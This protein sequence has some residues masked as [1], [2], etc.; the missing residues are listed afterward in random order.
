MRA[1]VPL[2][3][4]DVEYI[5]AG[6]VTLEALCTL[7]A[8][9]PEDI[10]ALI[11]DG[12]LPCPSYVL[13]DGTE[14]FPPD[15]FSLVDAAGGVDALPAHFEG[16][17]LRAA[18]AAGVPATAAQAAEEW[19]GY[20]S[21]EYGVCLRVVTPENIVV[22]ERLVALI[23]EQLASPQ[24]ADAAWAAALRERVDAL[25]AFTRPFAPSDRARFGGPVSRDRCVTAPRQRY[26]EIFGNGPPATQGAACLRKAGPQLLNVEP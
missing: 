18:A 15:Y 4:A 1:S 7:R 10:R 25:D 19:R 21:G 6:F 20:L 11:G 24:P 13:G 3:P 26:P 22:K 12:R 23:S 14:M 9:R 5:T 2:T 17:Y 8:E 16:R